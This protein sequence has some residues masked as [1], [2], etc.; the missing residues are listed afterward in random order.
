MSATSLQDFCSDGTIDELLS[1]ITLLTSLKVVGKNDKNAIFE[2]LSTFGKD[3]NIVGLIELG[4]WVTEVW[5]SYAS[6]DNLPDS[7]INHLSEHADEIQHVSSNFLSYHNIQ[8]ENTFPED[9]KEGYRE[10]GKLVEH[11]NRYFPAIKLTQDLNTLLDRLKNNVS[12]LE[13]LNIVINDIY[14]MVKTIDYVH[15]FPE[16]IARKIRSKLNQTKMFLENL[17]SNQVQQD[18]RTSF[19]HFLEKEGVIESIQH[20]IEK[21]KDRLKQKSLED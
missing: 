2:Y 5:K 20:I 17:K 1:A 21:M 10:L 9:L 6:Y 14:V 19:D 3:S 8:K 15:K 13:Q 18:N 7:V 16:P 12:S 4:K 11:L